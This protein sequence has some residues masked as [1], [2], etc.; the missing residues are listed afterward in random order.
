MLIFGELEIRRRPGG[1]TGIDL[2]EWVKLHCGGSRATRPQ[3]LHQ[4]GGCSL[5][6]TGEQE[7]V[8]LY[9][10]IRLNGFAFFINHL[11]LQL[12]IIFRS[13]ATTRIFFHTPLRG[14]VSLGYMFIIWVIFLRLLLVN[15]CNVLVA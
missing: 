5:K 10:L 8:G 4:Q 3:R 13:T 6:G 7:N 2:H 14:D 1:P 9:F 15:I 11:Q 12:L